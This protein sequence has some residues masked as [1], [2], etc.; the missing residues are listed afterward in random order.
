MQLK[1]KN[2]AKDRGELKDKNK[3]RQKFAD[4]VDKSM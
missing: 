4:Y 2:T 3:E 1:D